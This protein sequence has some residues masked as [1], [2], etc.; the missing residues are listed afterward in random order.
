MTSIDDIAIDTL[1]RT[2][3][4]EARSEGVAGMEAVASVVANRVAV[5]RAH[6]G[7]YWW[8]HD[9]AS[10]CRK[11][12]QFSC[13]NANDPNRARLLAVTDS[14]IHF[15]TCL[16]IARRCFYGTLADTTHG[17]THYHTVDILP[18]WAK[19]QTPVAT[20]GHHIFY[21]LEG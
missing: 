18:A 6:G 3:W 19:G 11:P 9:I 15:V 14:N 12:F 21:K 20:I 10:V 8:G 13:W 17:A 7:S 2:I 16:R 1:A 5:A 4:G